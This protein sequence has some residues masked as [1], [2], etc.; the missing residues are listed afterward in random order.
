MFSVCIQ[1]ALQVYKIHK[2][3][4]K[5]QTIRKLQDEKVRE[6]WINDSCE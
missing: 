2:T 6:G 1:N 5:I 4:R 3:G